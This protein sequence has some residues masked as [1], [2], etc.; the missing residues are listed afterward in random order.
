M[1]LSRTSHPLAGSAV[2]GCV[3]FLSVSM[4]ECHCVIKFSK[5]RMSAVFASLVA[6]LGAGPSCPACPPHSLS[7][8]ATPRAP[9]ELYGETE[10]QASGCSTG[11]WGA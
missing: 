1:L 3:V 7:F 11:L 9:P 4:N 10:V 6:L 5:S 2:W 8:R